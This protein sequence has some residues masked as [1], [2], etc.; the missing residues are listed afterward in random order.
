M[1]APITTDVDIVIRVQVVGEPRDVEGCRDALDCLA[2]VMAVQAEDGLYRLGHPDAECDDIPNEPVAT[3]LSTKVHAVLIGADGA[4]QAR[5][6]RLKEIAEELA[7]IASHAVHVP[8]KT[9]AMDARI[10]AL[11]HELE[12]DRQ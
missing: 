8:G 7:T 2:D 12:G 5:C 11:V 6:D 1:S 4:L 3:I 9:T 10:A